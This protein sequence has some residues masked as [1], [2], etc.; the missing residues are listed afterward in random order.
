MTLRGL[1]GW[2]CLFLIVAC[3][4]TGDATV[5]AQQRTLGGVVQPTR[6]VM[7]VK[8]SGDAPARLA[9]Y[10]FLHRTLDEGLPVHVMAGINA[11]VD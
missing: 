5:E 4:R 6:V 7:A 9:D 8:E 10:L 1:C 2:A 3:S 11:C